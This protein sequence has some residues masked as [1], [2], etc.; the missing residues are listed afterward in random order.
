MKNGEILAKGSSGNSF[1]RENFEQVFGI[2]VLLDG[3]P[4]SGRTENYDELH[5]MSSEFRV[6]SSEFVRLKNFE[7]ETWN[8]EPILTINKDKNAEERGEMPR[9]PTQP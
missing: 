5:V 3:H 9:L 8:L 6:Q 1:D 2:G 7:L 4:V